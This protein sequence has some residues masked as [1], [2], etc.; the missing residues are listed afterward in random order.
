VDLENERTDDRLL[1]LAARDRL[2][3]IELAD[4][5]GFA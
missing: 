2:K 3:V 4:M 1:R 5:V